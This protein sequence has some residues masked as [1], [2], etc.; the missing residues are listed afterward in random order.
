[1]TTATATP[2]ARDVAC[3]FCTAAPGQPCTEDGNTVTVHLS[4]VAAAVT[5]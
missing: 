3:P 1:M 5:R 4:R 2:T